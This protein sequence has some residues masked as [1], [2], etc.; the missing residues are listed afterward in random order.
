V[1]K[2]TRWTTAGFDNV[3]IDG[4]EGNRVKNERKVT[5]KIKIDRAEFDKHNASIRYAIKNSRP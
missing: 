4:D 5:T 2:V 1:S 3:C